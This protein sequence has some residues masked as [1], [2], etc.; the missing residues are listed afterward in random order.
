MNKRL[1]KK[2]ETYKKK[3]LKFNE[4][5]EEYYK[6][7]PQRVLPIIDCTIVGHEPFEPYEI[8]ELEDEIGF[9]VYTTDG[10]DM[11]IRIQKDCDGKEFVYGWDCADGMDTLEDSIRYDRR[12]L[13]KAWRIWK[14]DNPDL[15]LEKDDEEE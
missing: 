2:I 12:R 13:N 15:E 5:L 1:L 6:Q 10:L 7:D 3:V 9:R 8:Q 4:D 11:V 14:S